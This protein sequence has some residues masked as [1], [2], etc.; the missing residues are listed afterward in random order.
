MTVAAVESGDGAT[1]QGV[2]IDGEQLRVTLDRRDET[3]AVLIEARSRDGEDDRDDWR[4]PVLFGPQRL[5]PDGIVRRELAI[6]GWR[7]EVELEQEARAA[8]RDRARRTGAAAAGGGRGELRAIIPGKIVAVD[9]RAGDSVTAGQRLLVVEAMKMQNEL[10]APRDG[11][12]ERVAIASGATVER[13]DLLV[14][15]R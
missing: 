7:I 4:T 9:V 2:E 3:R 6:D 1:S 10:V 8:L 12:V 11:V 13:N 15:I 5:G 14:V